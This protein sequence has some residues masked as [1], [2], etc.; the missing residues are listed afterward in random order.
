M[1]NKL[2]GTGVAIV[3]P[4]H[5]DETIDFASL[6]KLIEFQ[7][8]NKVEYIVVL[9]TTGE[10]ATLNKDEKK[11]VVEFVI[12]TVDKR[13]PVIVGIGGNNTREVLKNIESTDFDGIDGIL[14]VCPY[15]NKPTQEGIYQ[16]Y[17][18]IATNS[19]VPVIMYNVPSRTGVN[20]AADTS[21][22]LAKDFK[23]IIAV[24][25]AS[26]NLEQ[27]MKI[28]KGKPEGFMVI[29]GDDALTLPMIAAG[30][31][32]VISV[33]ANA[34]PEDFSEM[35][36]LTLDGNIKEAQK[37]QYKLLDIYEAMFMEGSPGGIKAALEIL[38]HCKN[39]FKL[40]VVAVSKSTYDHIKKLIANY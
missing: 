1:Q 21:L 17:K 25:E 26:G 30:A 38:G 5:K 24:K 35:V 10:S 23:N 14:S 16:H 15:Y 13:T 7:I 32:G 29:S 40:P 39:Y 20:M 2:R 3:T 33:T 6:K 8:E 34:F 9:G 28:I 18:A 22:R 19:P 27:I 4:F 11:A 37:L 36:R 31:N 12:D